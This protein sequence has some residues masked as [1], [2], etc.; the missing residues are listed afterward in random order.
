MSNLA[1]YETQERKELNERI[2]AYFD[3]SY[4]YALK[5]VKDTELA[6]DLVQHMVLKVYMAEPYAKALGEKYFK[7]SIDNLIEHHMNSAEKR[8]T[9]ATEFLPETKDIKAFEQQVADRLEIQYLKAFMT[10][11]EW[12]A[13]TMFAEGYTYAEIYKKMNISKK[14]LERMLAKLRVKMQSKKRKSDRG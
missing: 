6:K 10:D 14:Q 11:M 13:V 8:Y 5:R 7:T 1:I 2:M 9:R 12:T 4:S 3:M